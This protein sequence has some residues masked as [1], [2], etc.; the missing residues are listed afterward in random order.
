MNS[1]FLL[2]IG[3]EGERKRRTSE[4]D[5][6]GEFWPAYPFCLYA[7]MSFMVCASMPEEK[8]NKAIAIVRFLNIFMIYQV[9]SHYRRAFVGKVPS[10]QQ[11]LS[12]FFI[13]L[14]S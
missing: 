11:E 2:C 13:T 3:E 6:E 9:V 5:S 12:L 1:V 8:A 14:Y 4:T 10:G 7:G